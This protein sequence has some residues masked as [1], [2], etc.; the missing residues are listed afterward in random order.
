MNSSNF[1][2]DLT[3]KCNFLST[4]ICYVSFVESSLSLTVC[5]FPAVKSH[6]ASRWPRWASLIRSGLS[7]SF[8]GFF[9]ECRQPWKG[10]TPRRRSRLGDFCFIFVWFFAVH[11]FVL[12]FVKLLWVL[13]LGFSWECD[14]AV[15][16]FLGFS[17]ECEWRWRV[18]GWS[19]TVAMSRYYYY[20]KKCGLAVNDWDV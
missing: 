5:L 10:A 16:L 6:W 11:E 7:L 4:L 9:G 15:N 14:F 1:N 17:D 20:K 2:S 18:E 13:S 12:V 19:L 3:F 8:V